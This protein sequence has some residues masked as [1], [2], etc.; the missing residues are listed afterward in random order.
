MADHNHRNAQI[1]AVHLINNDVLPAFEA[2]G[3][4]IAVVLSDNGR[5]FCGRPDLH[6][7]ELFLQL[8]E[9]EHRTTKVKRPQSNGISN[10]CTGRSRTSTSASRDAGPGSRR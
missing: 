5:E 1:T 7:Y 8:E 4:K 6:P 2:A 3:V 10:G 9:I